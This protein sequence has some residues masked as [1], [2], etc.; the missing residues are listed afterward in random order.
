MQPPANTASTLTGGFA[1]AIGLAD[2]SLEIT[3]K[4]VEEV[5]RCADLLPPRLPI[6]I[7]FLGNESDAQRIAAAGTICAQG[8]Q[9]VSI[10]SGRRLG[11]VEQLDAL[12]AGLARH[13]KSLSIIVVGG[14][15]V[16]AAGPFEAAVDILDSGILTRHPVSHV[17]IVGYPQGHH[18]IADDIL[19]DALREKAELLDRSGR[20]FEI[21][22]QYCLEPHAVI[23]WLGRLRAFGR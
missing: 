7:A 2:F 18:R 12:L 23:D 22:T 3:G 10:L 15:P 6:N 9:P 21:T 14:D 11:S 16:S 8:L 4:A 13:S 1:S 20:T 19:W 17:G 5:V